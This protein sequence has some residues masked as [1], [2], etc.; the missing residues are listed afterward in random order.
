MCKIRDEAR[1]RKGVRVRYNV[2]EQ[3]SK[4]H[5]VGKKMV[6]V[7]GKIIIINLLYY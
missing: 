6:D 7:E 5:K 1:K 3:E 4:I 2:M